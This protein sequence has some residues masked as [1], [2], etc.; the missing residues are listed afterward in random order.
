MKFLVLLTAVLFSLQLQARD[1]RHKFM[2][3]EAMTTDAAK[4]KLDSNIKFYFGKSKYPKVKEDHGV[5]TSNKKTNAF[6][7]SDHEACKWV[8]LSALLSFQKRA[9]SM[10]A[11][12]IVDIE[13]YYKKNKFVSSKKYECGAGALM[14]GVT[15]KG[16]VVTIK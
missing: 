11:N 10:G 3:E 13:S 1:T 5:F 16:R 12:A 9:Q 2:I 15:L 7:K 8:F 4:G 6:N 14:A